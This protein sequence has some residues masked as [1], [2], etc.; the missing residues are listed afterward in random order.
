M[1]LQIGDKV[2][3]IKDR[4][5]RPDNPMP[6]RPHTIFDIEKCEDKDRKCPADCP[7]MIS[8]DLKEFK[9]YAFESCLPKHKGKQFLVI[10][11]IPKSTHDWRDY[12]FDKSMCLV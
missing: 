1:K 3:P 9:C 10:K 8:L 7:G 4:F 5:I 6:L 12:V 2:I 11:K